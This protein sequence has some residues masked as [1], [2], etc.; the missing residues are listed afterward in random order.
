MRRG[1]AG[2]WCGGDGAEGMCGREVREEVREEVRRDVALSV[3]AFWA[4]AAHP[5]RQKHRE[6]P[7]PGASAPAFAATVEPASMH[8]TYGEAH[9]QRVMKRVLGDVL[10]NVPGDLLRNVPRDLLRVRA[11]DGLH[12]AAIL[13]F[14]PKLGNR[15]KVFPVYTL[16]RASIIDFRPRLGNRCMVFPVYTLIRASILDFRPRL[17]NR[18]KVFPV[19][20][21]L[22][23]SILDFKPKL[24]NRCSVSSL[25]RRIARLQRP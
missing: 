19:Y 21:L 22:R 8:N 12:P 10:G 25:Q 1:C 9:G 23:A 16:F 24:A 20:P 17:G 14:R 6:M 11:K 15:C 4:G 3:A 7:P 5:R 18:C 13:D 2:G